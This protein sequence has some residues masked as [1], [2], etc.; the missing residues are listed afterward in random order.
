MPTSIPYLCGSIASKP[1]DLGVRMHNAAYADL[2]IPYTYIAFGLD[3]TRAAI[4]AM[5]SLGMVGLSVGVPHKV[6]IMQYLDEIDPIAR[7]IGAVNAVVNRNSKL[8][9]YNVDWMGAE[10]AFKEALS[11]NGK[12][13]LVIGAGGAARSICYA[14]KRNDAQITI[15]NR[16]LAKAQTLARDFG[17]ARYGALSDFAAYSEYDVFVN[18]TSVG[19]FDEESCP[20]A[21]QDVPHGKTVFEAVFFPVKTKLVQLAEK[22]GC[23]IVPGI[24]MLVHLAGR[25]FELYTGLKPSFE[26][27]EKALM[28]GLEKKTG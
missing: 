16:D 25:Q 13:F 8:I 9:G 5:R 28:Q 4:A 14:L 11:I 7:K 23:R 2:G 1:S 21:E 19:F 3:D 18:A 17:I 6:E 24:R 22:R 15:L 12:R 27:M 10:A 20:I 26:V